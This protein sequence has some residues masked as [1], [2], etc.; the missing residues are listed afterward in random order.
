MLFGN[1]GGTMK[2]DNRTYRLAVGIALAAAFIL[3]WLSLGV[4][5]IGKDGDPA[6]LMYFAHLPVEV[7]GPL[8]DRGRSGVS[9]RDC[10]DC[11]V[12]P[13]VERAGRDPGA[14]WFFRRVVC[15]FGLAISACCA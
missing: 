13:S 9:R 11:K 2:A 1:A 12:G 7:L 8:H 3:V 4:G 15:W 6:N 14:K 5:I 10:A